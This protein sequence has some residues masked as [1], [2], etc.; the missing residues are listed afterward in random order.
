MGTPPGTVAGLPAIHPIEAVHPVER[1]MVAALDAAAV[2]PL[3][4]LEVTA[5]PDVI[6]GVRPVFLRA[7]LLERIPK[8]KLPVG[9]FI[10]NGA[11]ILDVDDPLDLSGI[12]LKYLVRFTNCR[13]LGG[14]DLSD[15][16]IIGFDLISGETSEI[17]ADRLNAEGSLL[18]RAPVPD[19][20]GPLAEPRGGPFLV[21]RRIRLCGA[22]IH[23]NLDLRGC[24]LSGQGDQERIPLFADGLTVEG[25]VLLGNGFRAIGEVRLNGSQITRNLDCAGA[26]LRSTQRYSLS[27]AGATVK[28]SVYLTKLE[29]DN[30]AEIRFS[31]I[32]TVRFDGATINGGLDFAGGIFTA[33]PFGPAGVPQD[34]LPEEDWYAVSGDGL[35]LGGDMLFIKCELQGSVSLISA[36][37][38]G[39]FRCENARFDFPGEETL[40]ADGID[41]T[42]T[43]FFRDKTVT[44]GIVRFA[45]ANLRQGFRGTD[46]IFD[47]TGDYGHRFDNKSLVAE[48]YD[49]GQNATGER[50]GLCGIYAPRA[51]ITGKF[52][53]QNIRKLPAEGR[54]H[55]ELW[56]YLFGSTADIV[57]DHQE[58]WAVLDR[59]DVTDCRYDRLAMPSNEFDWRFYELDRQ[60]AILNRDTRI[61]NWIL[62]C[63]IMSGRAARLDEAIR[64]FKPQPY[65]QLARVARQAGHEAAANR[66]FVQLE[67]N[68]TRYSNFGRVRQ[69]AR[70][71]LDGVL[72]YGFA[73]FRPVWILL[74]WAVFSAFCFEVAYQRGAIVA[75]SSDQPRVTF[76]ALVY[77]IDTLVP[78]VDLN[79][80]K[81]WIVEPL[82]AESRILH[83]AGPMGCQWRGVVC[84]FPD[85]GP[86][87]LVF[88]NTFFGWV[89]TT[90]FAAGI[91][92]LL[93]TGRE[94]G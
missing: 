1:A 11:T 9:R 72:T 39:D 81:N 20:R 77:A 50:R 33:W 38:A 74:A 4:Q 22:K 18:V 57:E 36:R 56:L 63:K 48:L 17:F 31:S 3:R 28:G 40:V 30:Q 89:M 60:Y 34:V 83:I 73:K 71:I 51:T 10:L 23:G 82:S 15:S 47:R 66:I 27:A 21:S 86:G 78:I 41:V 37:V 64:R 53:W 13:F 93:R 87:L 45:Q 91:T 43:T 32:G 75:S 79:Q 14:I 8:S 19:E 7:F 90:F 54:G 94:D 70:H 2:G 69:L 59:F 76:N 24:W 12:E 44:N 80:K 46:V 92:G 42:G 49:L 68:R 61:K 55:Y 6:S 52:R 16:K 85:W 67:R 25:N 65:M 84:Q 26:T 35:I 29:A 88:F 58:S 62:A 5:D